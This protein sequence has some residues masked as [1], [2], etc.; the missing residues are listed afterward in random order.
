MATV[1]FSYGLVLCIIYQLILTILVSSFMDDFLLLFIIKINIPTAKL[2]MQYRIYSMMIFQVLKEL[3]LASLSAQYNHK[4]SML[5]IMLSESVEII[6]QIFGSFL[7]FGGK[8]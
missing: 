4:K 3:S 5:C 7:I 8:I 1:V 2:M 6:L